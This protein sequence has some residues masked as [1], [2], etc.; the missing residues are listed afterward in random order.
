M[1]IYILWFEALSTS[2]SFRQRRAFVSAVCYHPKR[3]TLDNECMN[4]VCAPVE[5]MYRH[6]RYT[7]PRPSSPLTLTPS[8]PDRLVRWSSISDPTNSQSTPLASPLR[9]T[10]QAGETLYLPP[11]WWHHVRQSADDMGICIAL[12]WWYDIEMRGMHWVWLNFLRG[13]SIHLEREEVEP[14]D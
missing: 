8:S 13:D 12:N 9:F 1:K 6:A 3:L 2:P 14:S 5:R 4:M 10:V 7:R 11:G